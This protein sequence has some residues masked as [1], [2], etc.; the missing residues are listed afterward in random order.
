M[1]TQN[2]IPLP[3]EMQR[4]CQPFVRA[5]FI[6]DLLFISLKKAIHM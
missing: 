5:V 2:T 3:T 4:K 1:Y 6:W